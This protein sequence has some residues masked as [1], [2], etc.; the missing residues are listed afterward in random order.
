M[1]RDG[2]AVDQ[3]VL[4]AAP[5]AVLVFEP[6]YDDGRLL[7]FR[8]R[9]L[10][11]QAE[12]ILGLSVDEVS[13]RTM[14]E[15]IP[16]NREAGTFERYA[17]AFESGE[18]YID[19]FEFSSSTVSG[20][21]EVHAERVSDVL[22][23]WFDDIT[24]GVALEAAEQAAR[25][26]VDTVLSRVSD[27]VIGINHEWVI[28][29]V[30]V[31]ASRL[32]GVDRATLVGQSLW[33]AFPAAVGSDFEHHYRRAAS[34]GQ[35]VSFEA[36]YPEPLDSWYAIRA[37]PGPEGL[38]IFFQDAG[39]RRRL[40][41]RISQVERV[42]SIATLAG[43]IAH[44]FNNLLMVISGHTAMLLSD[45][46]E[47]DPTRDDVVAIQAAGER[48]T[49]LTRQL[50][51]FSRRQIVRPV[52]VDL[53]AAI[54]RALPSLPAILGP[55]ITV[56]V[57]AHPGPVL[58]EID[59]EELE[60]SLL[61]LAT[62]A[63]DAMGGRGNLVLE[64]ETVE[65]TSPHIAGDEVRQRRFG[66]L[67]LS[68]DGAGMEPSVL[69]RAVEPFFTTRPDGQGTG[70][71][72]SAVHGMARQAGGQLT[73]YSEPGVGTTARIYLPASEVDAVA[74]T[75]QASPGATA[76]PSAAR[77]LVVDDNESVRLLVERIL[78]D[79]GYEVVTAATGADAVRVAR[80][81][82]EPIHALIT[83]VV[84]PGADGHEL[85]TELREL[86]PGLPVLFVSGF[87]DHQAIRD[88]VPSGDVEF[89]AKPFSPAVL[90]DRV[91]ALLERVSR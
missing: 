79:R 17:A 65:L 38:T 61:H 35:T 80:S 82:P 64:T 75:G 72:L 12:R 36:Y 9:Y 40:E 1:A 39:P 91:G 83:D 71:G 10:N 20:W 2:D 60:R 78:T 88:G 66:V 4:D 8:W 13:G 62:N 68:D 90:A 27:G 54:A 48:L 77:L 33:D 14:L 29:F 73:L 74:P 55:Q 46:E 18:P 59:P 53:N 57:R 56:E 21:F 24:E 5:L 50:V 52:T 76:A 45:L 23:L 11:R 47:G 86:L 85:A 51:T 16:E 15:V 63:R 44:D 49:E 81:S 25:R 26:E 70:L 84:M 30:N 7:D 31:E 89:L 6:V 87:T 22:T 67:T 43:G 69:A 41:E 3:S 32:I 19:T 34:S 58:V 37:Y 42:E 28:T